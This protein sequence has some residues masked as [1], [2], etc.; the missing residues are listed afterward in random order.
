MWAGIA[1]KELEED[2]LMLPND[3]DRYE[4]CE[5]RSRGIKYNK[6]KTGHSLN[7]AAQVNSARHSRVIP[8][9]NL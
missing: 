5:R 6:A 2:Y 4:E 1:W 8:I 3:T 7:F 9:F